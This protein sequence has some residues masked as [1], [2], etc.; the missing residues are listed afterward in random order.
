M[1]TLKTIFFPFLLWKL[2]QLDR[3]SDY[4]QLI[5]S[6]C[7]SKQEFGARILEFFNDAGLSVFV[8]STDQDIREHKLT[9]D[10][11]TLLVM[12]R[13]KSGWVQKAE[14]GILSVRQ[15]EYYIHPIMGCRAKCHYCYLQARTMGRQPMHF[16]VGIDSLF[17]ELEH[18]K[19]AKETEELLFCTGEL[20]D[21]LADAKLY[22]IGA[23]L[24]SYFAEQVNVFLELRTKSCNVDSL[25]GIRHNKRTVV[26]FSISPH[27]FVKKYE[28]GTASLKE[29]L[30]AARRCQDAGYDIALKFEPIFMGFRWKQSYEET[31]NS[32]AACLNMEQIEHVSL[33]YL[34]W[35]AGLAEMP[36]FA[37]S[38]SRE[39]LMGQSIRYRPNKINF[40]ANME[41]R[42]RC[43]SWIRFLLM[44]YKVIDSVLWSMEEPSLVD[45]LSTV[46]TLK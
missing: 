4:R 42:L 9:Y 23:L 38:F 29:R 12:Y 27:A 1:T 2:P 15:N 44:K 43:Y 20:A 41:R 5:I 24:A 39:I 36:I 18:C 28:P 21:S 10:P 17:T 40:T 6:K 33:G 34:R 14:H 3:L 31:I 13:P 8:V 46:R 19:K 30:L 25:L 35:N 22:P 26:A 37:K 16:Y 7:A 45:A 11:A 32:I